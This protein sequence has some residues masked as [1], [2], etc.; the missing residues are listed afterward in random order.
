MTYMLLFFHPRETYMLLF[1]YPREKVGRKTY[2]LLSIYLLLWAQIK[3][4]PHRPDVWTAVGTALPGPR[5][6]W[7]APLFSAL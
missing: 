4:L 5:P 1:F 2:M 7:L 6:A 3:H